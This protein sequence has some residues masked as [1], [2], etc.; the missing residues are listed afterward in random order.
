MILTSQ[1]A[2]LAT[3]LDSF[4]K[5]QP[6]HHS[7]SFYRFWTSFGLHFGPFLTSQAATLATLLDS[8][9]EPQPAHNSNSFLIDFGPLLPSILHPF[10]IPNVRLRSVSLVLL[11]SPPP[12]LI[13]DRFWLQKDIQKGAE[14]MQIVPFA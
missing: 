13:L 8:F 1:G 4:F 11:A 7:K 12:F 14:S 9:F 3:F 2:T 10:W 6:D 5:Q